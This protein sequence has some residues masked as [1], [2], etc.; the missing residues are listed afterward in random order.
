MRERIRDL[1]FVYSAGLILGL[2]TGFQPAS[3]AGT[4]SVTLEN[5]G[6]VIIAAGLDS[7]RGFH[8]R[9]GPAPGQRSL[10]WQDG[11]LT[12]PDSLDVES[13]RGM[14]L[15]VPC[16]G[17]LSGLGHTGQLVFQDGI[18]KVSEPVVLSDGIMQ[19][20]LAAGELEFQGLRVRYTAPTAKGKDPRAGYLFLG[21][22]VLLIL[23][24]LRRAALKYR[25]KS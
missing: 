24:L 16:T 1:W 19:L 14:D 3:A 17:S 13:L 15:V 25:N 21:G 2:L 23:I 20:Y 12:L 22:M 8:W 11:V 6:H 5:P 18:Y 7:T 9:L 10:T 4:A